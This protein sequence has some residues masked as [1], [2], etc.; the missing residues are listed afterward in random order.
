MVLLHLCKVFFEVAQGIMVDYPDVLPIWLQKSL[1]VSG[2]LLYFQWVICL[3]VP[4]CYPF[5]FFWQKAKVC[6][7]ETEAL[8]AHIS[9]LLQKLFKVDEPHNCELRVGRPS[10][11]DVALN[12]V[13]P[14]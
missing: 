4:K 8:L 14:S 13:F 5:S 1:K 11:N 7:F 3:K 6:T 9:I 12:W 10:H 2:I